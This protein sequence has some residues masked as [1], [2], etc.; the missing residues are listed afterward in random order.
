M[1]GFTAKAHARAT[2]YPNVGPGV[3]AWLGLRYAETEDRFSLPRRASGQLQVNE[4]VEVPV[5]PQAPSRLNTF[6]G[7]GRLNPQTENAH[8]INIWAPENAANLPVVFFI[9]GGAWMTGGGSEEKYD[10]ARL[11]A[12][13]LVVVT[14]NYRLGPLGHLGDQSEVDLPLP[15]EDLVVALG[16][17]YENIALY[18][19][20]S[21]RITVV[22]QSAGGWYGHLLSMLDQTRG[23]VHQVAHLSMGTRQ[24]WSQNRQQRV[25]QKVSEVA[26]PA[27]LESL[28]VDQLLTAGFEGLLAARDSIYQAPLAHAGSGYLPVQTSGM[29]PGFLDPRSAAATTHACSVYLRCTRDETAAFFWNSEDHLDAS[30][31]RVDNELEKWHLADLPAALVRDDGYDGAGSGLSPYW[32]LVAVTSWKQ[33][34]RFPTEYAQE[35]EAAN[36]TTQIHHFDYQSPLK[37]LRSA[38]CFDLPFQFGNWEAWRD[39]PMLKG[40]SRE[41]FNEVSAKLML[42]L[43]SFVS[44]Q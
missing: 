17:T 2:H 30:Q 22:G 5:F 32:Q 16:W 9:H 43:A 29:P 38:H 6:M 23:L 8:F 3:T 15:L 35:L 37:N 1:A 21:D 4:L 33:F 36:I 19:G 31:E 14:V 39:A 26:A 42:S 41:D 34:Q 13:G 20:D 25:H 27:L 40:V 7:E 18:G 11:A 44:E 12:L 24:P 10:G 28:P